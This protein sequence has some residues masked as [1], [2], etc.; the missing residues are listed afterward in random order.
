M[1][2]A[3]LATYAWEGEDILIRKL[4]TDVLRIDGPGRFIDIGAHHPIDCS[5]TYS[6]YQSGWRGVNIDAMPGSMAA[7]HEH[8]PEDCNLEVGVSSTEGEMLFSRFSSPMLNGFLDPGTIA[9]HVRRG[10]VLLD[11]I[12]VPVR[13]L[14]ALLEENDV[15]HHPDVM[16]L[17]VEGHE[18]PVLE[19]NDWDRWRPKMIVAEVLNP[20]GVCDVVK[21]LRRPVSRY[22]TEKHGYG[23]VS[24]LHLSLIFMDRKYL[25]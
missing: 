25:V 6:L 1:T 10:E 12:S 11:Q 8:R 24:R 3:K 2:L 4:A 15:P 7:F 18:M 20:G 19:T 16:S 21:I 5:N 23:L 17:V 14:A 13:P 22:L 9:F